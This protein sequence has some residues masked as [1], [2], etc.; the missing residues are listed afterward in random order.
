MLF[1]NGKLQDILSGFKYNV[2]RGIY[3]ELQTSK[4][5]QNLN[6]TS[7]TQEKLKY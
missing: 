6:F 7:K 5:R 1:L 3:I 2:N 4:M